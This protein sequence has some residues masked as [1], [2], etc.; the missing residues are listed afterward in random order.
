MIEFAGRAIVDL[1]IGFN[2]DVDR[3][4]GAAVLQVPLPLSPARSGFGPSCSLSYSS[5]AH[6]NSA[7]GV[8]WQL[9]GLPRVDIDVR[10]H[11]PRWDGTDG[12]VFG[13][14]ELVPWLEPQGGSFGPRGFADATW[15]IAFYRSRTG[16]A[17]S[18]VE[19]WVE[20][21]T[22]RVHFQTRDARNS[23]AIFGA[24]PDGTSRLA[25]R[26]DPW[27]TC[28]W[29]P[30]VMVDATGNAIWFEYAAETLDGVDR[31][32]PYEQN[33]PPPAQR[34]LKRI[35]YGNVDPVTIDD[36]VRAG[37]RPATRWC[38]QTV[39]DYGDHSPAASP[40]AEPDRRWLA[41]P[42]AFTTCALG[43]EVRTYRL[44]RRI[45]SFHHFDELGPE[46]T[47]VGE[48]RLTHDENPAGAAL[49][50]FTH[51][52][53]RREPAGD[54]SRSQPSLRFTYS[55]PATAKAFAPVPRETE[56][57]MPAGFGGRCS[58][59]D[60]AGDGLPGI[61]A[62]S[63]RSWFYKPNLGDGRFGAQT[64]VLERPA[65][66]PGSY[67]LGDVDRDGDLDLSQLGG[68]LAGLFEHDRQEDGW[69]G[70]RPFPTLPHV[71]A[72]GS[73]AQWVDLN[74]D[75]RPDIVVA[76][77]DRLVWYPSQDEGF[78]EPIVRPLPR[79]GTGLP[80]LVEDF[81]LEMFFAD[82][83]GDGLIDLVR[84]RNGRVEYW[85]SLGNGWF[86]DAVV[87]DGAPQFAPYGE[88][89]PRRL[90][91]ADLDG[92]GT[93][94]LVY[95][96]IGEVSIWRNA[97]GNRLVEG[98]RL[99]GLPYLDNLSTTQIVDLL[100]D[101]RPCLV[102]S[103]PLPERRNPLQY[104]SLSPAERP[105]LL[106]T[107]DNSAGQ[108]ARLTHTWSASHYLRDQA[109]ERPWVSKLPMHVPVVDTLE[110]IDH[111]GSTG[112][113]QRFEY[114]DGVYD[115]N[116]RELRGF[117]QV[118]VYDTER[119]GGDPDAGALTTPSLVRTWFHLG[120]DMRVRA[121][122]YFD[123]GL[124]LLPAHVVDGDL[125]PGELDDALCAL[126]GR[127]IRTET[128]AVGA[129]P[130]T[131]H[132]FGVVQN[133]W[134]VRRTQP[135][136]DGALAAFA[137]VLS[138]T[139][140]AAYEQVGGDPRVV[141]RLTLDTDEYDQ[142]VR[143]AEVAY[144]R[145]AGHA[146]DAPA[147]GQLLARI[148]QHALVNVDGN[149]RFELGLDIDDRDFELLGV[150]PGQG[151]LLTH[152]RLSAADVAS[153][154]AHPYHHH[155]DPPPGVT[156][157]LLAW[158]QSIYWNETRDAA[159][160]LGQVGGLSLLHHEEDGCFAPELIADTFGT[161]VDDAR[162]AAVGYQLRDGLW[163]RPDGVQRY[164]PPLRFSLLAA[165]ESAGGGQTTFEYDAYA[166]ALIAETDALGNRAQA[167]IDYHQIAPARITDLNGNIHAAEYDPLGVIIATTTLGHVGE[168]SWGFDELV[169]AAHGTTAEVI[170][171]PALF[172]GGAASFTHYDLDAW[173]LHGT[174]PVVV[175]LT[176][177]NLLHDGHGGTPQARIQVGVKY[178]DGLGR[179]VQEKML[180]DPGPA[181]QRGADG[182]VVVDPA[183]RPVPAASETRWRVSGHV[184]YDRKNQAALTYEPYFS[185]TWAYEDD[186]VLARFGVGTVT[187]YDAV[188]RTVGQN[189]PD[190]TFTRVVYGAW[191]REEADANDTVMESAWRAVRE[192]RPPADPERQA[193]EATKPHAGTSTQI[194]FDPAG[195]EVAS[196]RRGGAAGDQRRETLLGGT[197]LPLA[198]IDPRGLTAF[199]YQRDMSGRQL[200]VRSVDAG[201]KWTL[202][203]VKDRIV[204]N[205]DGRGVELVTGYDLLDRPVAR[206][207][208]GLGLDH[209]VE[210][211][212]Y[213]ENV[214]DAAAR[215]LRGRLVAVRDQAGEVTLDR[216][217]PAGELLS[218]SRRLRTDLDG[219]PD[220][221]GPVALDSEMHT[222]ER[223]VDALGRPR[224]VTMADG[225]RRTFEYQRSGGLAR[226]RVSTLDGTL[227]EAP[228]LNDAEY[229]A[230]ARRTHAALGNGVTIDRQYDLET[231]RRTR[232]IASRGTRTLQDVSYTWD[233][234]GNLTR[235]VD[236]AQ[237]GPNAIIGG[238][239]LP[240][241]RDYLYDPHYRL[242]RATGRVHQALLE[243]EYI[244]AAAGMFKGTRHLTL[245]NGAAL[246][247][248]T[249]TFDYDASG[250]LQRVRH[251]GTTQ[252]WTTDLWISPTSNR[253][254]PAL[255]PNNLPVSNPESRFDSTGNLIAL[256][257]LR[258]MDWNWRGSLAGAVV[259]ERP[260]GTND[261]EVYTYGAD[262]I[263]VR[264]IAKR[265][266]EGD[267]VEVTEK[268]YLGDCER[269]RLWQG[270][271]LVLERW[272][273]HLGDG[274]ERLALL[275]RWVRDD[276][277]RETDTPSQ[278][279]LR[280]QVT[281]HQD[282]SE[283]EL[284]GAGNLLSYEEYFPYG[285]AAFIAGDAVR[286][287]GIKESR[288]TG[289]EYDGATG[290]YS[291]GH[292]YY[293]P[294]TGRWLSPDP[295]GPEDDLNLY[296]FVLGNPV[297]RVDR[298][299]LDTEKPRQP[300]GIAMDK[301]L[302]DAQNLARFNASD[303]A[304]REG[305]WGTRVER[306]GK[307]LNVVK[308]IEI[309][310]EASA[311]ER[312]ERGALGEFREAFFGLVVGGQKEGPP[313]LGEQGPHGSPGGK[314]KT[315]DPGA[316][317]TPGAKP[318]GVDPGAGGLGVQGGKAGGGGN[319]ESQTPG[320]GKQG[321]GETAGKGK[322]E[323]RGDTA[324][325]EPHGG[326]G[327]HPPGHDH[328]PGHGEHEGKTGGHG[329]GRIG[330]PKPGGDKDKKPGGG[331]GSSTGVNDG[332]PNGI[333]G[334]VAGGLGQV[335]AQDGRSGQGLDNGGSD[336]RPPAGYT[337]PGM[338]GG[339]DPN[340]RPDGAP[341][342][343]RG[344]LG[345]KAAQGHGTQGTGQGD[346]P[347]PGKPAPPMSA[348]EQIARGLNTVSAIVNMAIPHEDRNG[349][350]WGI[351]AGMN[352]SGF[353]NP[354][355]AIVSNVVLTVVAVVSMGKGKAAQGLRRLAGW[356]R[357][358]LRN[359]LKFL[360]SQAAFKSAI[361]RIAR[362]EALGEA[363]K[364]ILRAHARAV[365][366][367]KNNVNLLNSGIV[368][369]HR[370]PLEYAHL[371]QNVNPSA[372]KNLV[373]M[374]QGAHTAL[375][376]SWTA[377]RVAFNPTNAATVAERT[378]L[379]TEVDLMVKALDRLFGM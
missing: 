228:V 342:T 155:E 218:E 162:L 158:H 285:G 358:N 40:A 257:H 172:L 124:P 229:D 287:V 312:E 179:V 125:A 372:L 371:F 245:N 377:F 131:S 365:F 44:C 217:D 188:G 251:L 232:Q 11:F 1:S 152:E 331:R 291:Y 226:L 355:A 357:A 335:P 166:I 87:L 280:F 175:A 156:A 299:G 286:E 72:L 284:D 354:V 136:L 244:P 31:A 82:M 178:L 28:R 304:R 46:P 103:S 165:K 33:R 265:L 356:Q 13:G 133:S 118:D 116:K 270:D 194:C 330:A 35:L 120:N 176:A 117:G 163:W 189:L 273:S 231:A 352:P 237:Q 254:L 135:A 54:V 121:P 70:F 100:G 275:D 18:R 353:N 62:E 279:R 216:Y 250:N 341:G 374:T 368:I 332:S 283:M 294:W 16:G 36:S 362:G 61:L 195:R 74:G 215:N 85:P 343:L 240:A 187:R 373:P 93:A 302:S 141:H 19:K 71:E 293:A 140:E 96:G 20:R 348:T 366:E 238:T 181:I 90:R 88:F 107:V 223:Y 363:E 277:A 338:A 290:L 10:D 55:A 157:R 198:M 153:A 301:K 329:T 39:F 255:D 313:S 50:E 164:G 151:Q 379:R 56:E 350:Q 340:G 197:G 202:L 256:S 105:G 15:S 264:K 139:L 17:D 81:A 142:I 206:H 57:N 108:E 68:R 300:F 234:V 360:E 47:L 222:C 359:T 305:I 336:Q 248:F 134:R 278:P 367:L 339:T 143:E 288:Y 98:P 236:A 260:G 319:T 347:K 106:L 128:W 201:E 241:Q 261:G 174:P 242:T 370:I 111:I 317:G 230:L 220:W 5:S 292:R 130:L 221:S 247:S 27:R 268:L 225:T 235:L 122:G 224:T 95:L 84:V 308:W 78:A 127:P 23:I 99:S 161:R 207:V 112:S 322:G 315:G 21:A 246:E 190:G 52:G 209:R 102:W 69:R 320:Q 65:T 104:L 6:G 58:L 346:A 321:E 73:R 274:N 38:F 266:V 316:P 269:T 67:A 307:D 182:S 123:P 138:E 77:D 113:L 159:L 94:D 249:R 79:S 170:A 213:G 184:V 169:A 110:L 276:L 146:L 160:P 37:L 376:L 203:D 361:S 252:S 171:Q 43:F 64:L 243:H 148:H 144:P 76:A 75:G 212:V 204:Q 12:Y 333:R 296:Q 318:T 66:R 168:D 14:E 233:P 26:N 7:F 150:V 349:K 115:G 191:S 309:P 8:G 219:E 253:S 325:T 9:S 211:W 114:H 311:K 267:L 3:L 310:R 180:V 63:D 259:T 281:S 328:P 334:G 378:A 129:D 326:A 53:H 327:L 192:A 324:G 282:S 205:W 289:K 183:G 91:F 86:G 109:A 89:D 173:R 271:K 32:A 154:L 375:H 263:R 59:V 119:A 60:L 147:Q 42:D 41:R 25:D 272:T 132:P 80:T 45:L 210:E 306:K 177:E 92:S 298:D 137:A 196:L 344:G 185:P 49:L 4:T 262:G 126:T 258:R 345:D 101:G 323:R 167:E 97:A 314:G 297:T 214:P 48:V 34:Y 227:V 208:R 24:R 51:V 186:S 30:E 239:T 29:F 83:N 337:P 149:E 22:G 364:S 295:L 199:S 2:L 351:W 200:F 145:R 303:V 369:H 193:L